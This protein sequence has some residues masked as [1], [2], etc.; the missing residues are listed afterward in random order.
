MCFSIIDYNTGA[1]SMFTGIV[2]GLLKIE[3]VVK[4]PGMTSYAAAFTEELLQGL[5]VGASV[6]VDG[7]CQT[8]VKIDQ[9]LVWFDA[10]RET[11]ERTTIKFLREGMFVNVERAAR[12]GEEIGGHVLSGH[13]YGTA[14]IA[15]TDRFENNKIVTFT[16]EPAWMKYFFPKGYI[17]LDGVSLTL[18]DV[19][20]SG[21]FTVHLIPET[22]RR[23]TLG[24]KK[25][26]SLVNLEFDSQTQAIVDSVERILCRHP[27]PALSS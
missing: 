4:K 12:F 27:I 23:T 15:K 6:S 7:V 21:W 11:L 10:I 18:V 9:T 2:R 22:L 19:E 5:Q 25:E 14:S 1:N 16:C 20:P 26:G 24:F 13:I 8:V 17:A 3:K